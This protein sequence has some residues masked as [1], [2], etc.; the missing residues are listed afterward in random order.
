MPE[1]DLTDAEKIALRRSVLDADSVGAR[2][3]AI[4]AAEDALAAEWAVRRPLIAV[5][6]A[7]L[8]QAVAAHDVAAGAV[9]RSQA[10]RDAQAAVDA[11]L[12]ALHTRERTV[13]VATEAEFLAA[14]AQ[15]RQAYHAAIVSRDALTV[16]ARAALAAAAAEVEADPV[17]RQA[18]ADAAA[19]LDPLRGALL[20]ALEA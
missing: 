8:H 13:R 20:A 17:F 4:R 3:Q 6:E 15:E 10:W 19:A 12:R 18:H 1:P 14:T 11:A 16:S 9:R 2:A 7:P 5:V